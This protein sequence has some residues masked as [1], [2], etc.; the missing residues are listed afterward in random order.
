MDL[1]WNF[2]CCSHVF[3]T[4]HK[5]STQV[6]FLFS[7]VHYPT[8]NKIFIPGYDLHQCL[9]V[10]PTYNGLPNM[11]DC[12]VE[13]L[14]DKIETFERSCWKKGE[15][16]SMVNSE[17]YSMEI[18]H[19]CGWAWYIMKAVH[20]LCKKMCRKYTNF[21]TESPESKAMEDTLECV[22]E[23]KAILEH[24]KYCS[25]YNPRENITGFTINMMLRLL[26]KAI[27]TMES[28]LRHVEEH[29][30]NIQAE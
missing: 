14:I 1:A 4:V 18:P 27:D 23:V 3:G 13:Y 22:H 24:L 8:H 26:R 25:R 20:G 9:M 6:G 15:L 5:K 7:R 21:D 29:H 17:L 28:F 19:D 11:D 2:F 10:Y 16:I 12:T 30:R